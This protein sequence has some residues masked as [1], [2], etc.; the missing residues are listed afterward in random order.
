MTRLAPVLHS[1]DL[2]LA[3]LC[4]ARLDGEL[5]A[6]DGAFCPIDE[7]VSPLHRAHAA[8]QAGAGRLIAEQRTA[9]W[10]WGAL[11]SPPA[12]HQWCVS[13]GA[14]ARAPH[15]A[16]GVVREVVI[17][18]DEIAVLGRVRVT[19]PLR[20]VVDVAR[21]SPV[22]AGEEQQLVAAL[23]ELGGIRL[24]DC[25]GA[26]ERRRNLPAKTQAWARIR[27]AWPGPAC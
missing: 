8:A 24:A 15:P 26:L 16:R 6:L 10:I 23:I 12:R 9:A 17:D 11:L 4:A 2:P 14:R 18:A 25:R 7:P 22:F 20:T 3:E 19:T 13:T 1:A 21:F 27:G 5:V